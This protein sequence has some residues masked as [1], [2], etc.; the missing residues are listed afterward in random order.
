MKVCAVFLAILTLGMLMACSNA[1]PAIM[2][3]PATSPIFTITI[4]GD[5]IVSKNSEVVIENFHKGAR[6]EVTYRIN[7]M[8][9]ATIMPVIYP[10]MDANVLDY[11]KANGHVNAP[12]FV[13]DWIQIQTPTL[14]E[15]N[16]FGDFLVAFQMPKDAEKTPGKFAFQI[17]VSTEVKGQPVGAVGI[18]WMINMR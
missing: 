12:A 13:R 6:A 10:I 4:T 11:S 3:S 14:I 18:W 9:S 5:G 7:N 16:K 17:G 8:S 15:P 1:Q 2:P